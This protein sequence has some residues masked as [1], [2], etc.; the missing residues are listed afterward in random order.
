MRL[1]RRAEGFRGIAFRGNGKGER[2]DRIRRR[3]E[4]PKRRLSEK[5]KGIEP[6]PSRREV[7]LG[8]V[9]EGGEADEEKHE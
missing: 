9:T 1:E 5:G 6:G 2:G 8:A 7:L 4:N 3:R